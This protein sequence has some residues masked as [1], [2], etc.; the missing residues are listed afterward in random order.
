MIHVVPEGQRGTKPLITP[1]MA[2][3]SDVTGCLTQDHG[4]GKERVCIDG[5]MQDCGDSSVSA[6]ELPLSYAQPSVYYTALQFELFEN[7]M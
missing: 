4:D 3:I 7:V 2:M 6:M 5:L 1:V